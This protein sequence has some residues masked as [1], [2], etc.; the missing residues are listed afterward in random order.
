MLSLGIKKRLKS[1]DRDPKKTTTDGLQSLP[2]DSLWTVLGR[3]VKF[4]SPQHSLV[5]QTN[6]DHTQGRVTQMKVLVRDLRLSQN[7]Q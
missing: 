6:L 5:T 3:G 2:G 7:S 4:G 1:R